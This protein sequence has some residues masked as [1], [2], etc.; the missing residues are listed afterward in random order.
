MGKI[1]ST[2]Q[3][4]K[5]TSYT[6]II[7][8]VMC[9]NSIDGNPALTV[10]EK[11]LDAIFNANALP[12]C[13]PHELASR[14]GA[15]NEV[16]SRLDGI[17]LT[18]SPSNI[19][20]YRYG[21]DGIEALADPGR[22]RLSLALIRAALDQRIPLFA[23][24][25]GMQELVVATGGTLYR[26]VQEQPGFM[27][28]REDTSLPH[29]AQYDL[30]HPVSI[31]PGGLLAELLPD[32]QQFQVNSLHGQG[33]KHLGAEL[34]IEARAPDNLVEAVSVRNHPFALGVQWHPE[35]HS[36][37]DPPSRQLFES[38]I[39]ACRRNHHGIRGQQPTPQE[40]ELAAKRAF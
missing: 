35:W 10:H 14:E 8:V 38:F 30:V 28:H 13:L 24:C 23:A 32:Y 4:R 15:I 2:A 26:K 17:F 19:E 27:D 20:P 36:L 7:G 5:E 3:A 21:E 40:T 37:T 39:A 12:I 18:G 1:F 25:R 22:D 29:D 16:L 11:Y 34:T 6:P 33:A 9:A 31:E